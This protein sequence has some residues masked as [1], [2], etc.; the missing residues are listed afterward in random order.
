VTSGLS[1]GNEWVAE[2]WVNGVR[3]KRNESIT[4]TSCAHTCRNSEGV[5]TCSM[6]SMEHT[7]SYC[8]PSANNASAVVWKY[9]KDSADRANWGSPIAWVEAIPMFASEASIPVVLAPNL[10]R[11]WRYLQY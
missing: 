8:F 3:K 11:L 4:F 7:T 10:A 5:L 1:E 9:F 6:T 2:A